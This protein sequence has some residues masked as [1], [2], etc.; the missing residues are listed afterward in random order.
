M[1]RMAEPLRQHAIL[2]HPVEHAIRADDRRVDRAGEDQRAHQY[3]ESVEQQAQRQ[4]ADQVHR[5]AAD[6]VVQ[7]LRPHRIGNQHHG[8]KRNQRREYHAVDEDH[9]AR[10]PLL[11]AILDMY[12]LF[13]APGRWGRRHNASLAV[14]RP[15]RGVTRTPLRTPAGASPVDTNRREPWTAEYRTAATAARYDLV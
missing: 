9:E 5:K 14:E 8:E 11:A 2:G 10:A 15:S 3:D 12:G 7:I 1:V 6:Q 4:R 13:I